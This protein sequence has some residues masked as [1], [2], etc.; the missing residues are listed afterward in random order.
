[1]AYPLSESEAEYIV[2][3]IEEFDQKSS[4]EGYTD[5]EEAWELFMWIRDVL[6]GADTIEEEQTDYSDR[7]LEEQEREDFAQDG[8]FENMEAN[9]I[10]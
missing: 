4:E 10:L 7:L 8:Y 5:T 2:N 3:K 6:N 1:M 9:E